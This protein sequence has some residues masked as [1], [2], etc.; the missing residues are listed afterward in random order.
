M[1]ILLTALGLAS[2]KQPKS[3]ETIVSEHF[4][5]DSPNAQSPIR[6]QETQ[7]DSSISPLNSPGCL[8]F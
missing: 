8:F 5:L 1:K 3:N 2:P 7:N 4:G 6:E